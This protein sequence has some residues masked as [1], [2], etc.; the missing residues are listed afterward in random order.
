MKYI[1]HKCSNYIQDKAEARGLYV[2]THECIVLQT[3]LLGVC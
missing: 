3:A 1:M 2:V